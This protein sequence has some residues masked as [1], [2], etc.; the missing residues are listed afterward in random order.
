MLSGEPGIGKSRIVQALRNQLPE[1]AFVPLACYCS[2]SHVDGAFH[3]IISLLERR[4]DLSGMNRAQD[5]GETCNWC[6]G[7]TL[8]SLGYPDEALRRSL[9]AVER[10]REINQPF[11]L[12]FALDMGSF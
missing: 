6:A 2:P 10:A 5:L 11:S 4:G 8:F 7:L 1:N 3:P 9:A 12:A